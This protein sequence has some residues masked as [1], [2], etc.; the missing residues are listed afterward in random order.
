MV[1]KV[2]PDT[3]MSAS[4]LPALMGLSKYQSAND[5][6]LF[7]INAL[8]GL[9][10]KNFSNEAMD[11]GNQLEPL[12]LQEAARRLELIDLELD[13]P[14]ARFHEALPLCC[15]L[16]GTAVGTGQIVYTDTE[17]GIY[18]VGQDSIVLEGMGVLEA[19]LTGV[20]PEDVPP[21]YRGPV[22]LQAQ[23]D[24]VKAKWGAVA[25][26][27]Q[28]TQLRIFLFAPHEDTLDAIDRVTTVFQSKLDKWKATG[29]IDYY[30][31]QNSKDADRTWP[32]AKE[33]LEPVPL[34]HQVANIVTEILYNKDR[35]KELTAIIDERETAIKE[36][37]KE[38][39]IATAGDYIIKWGMRSYKA[40]PEKIVPAKEAYT[41]RQSTLSIKKV[42]AK[43]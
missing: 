6:L 24:I 34:G 31:P 15:S 39:G 27:Y 40:Q 17:K 14:H 1:S 18:V 5:E 37:M 41:I 3:M 22:Q 38:N 43:V 16:D 42:E 21:L 7:S 10:R 36:L 23:M 12:I 2:T 11:W 30:P 20:A 8:Q 26:L 9:E 13:H 25:T 33:E 19:K 28:G 4:R 35:I 32:E 29:E